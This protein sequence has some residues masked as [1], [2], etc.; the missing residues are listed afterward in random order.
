[1]PISGT[2]IISVCILQIIGETFHA[3]FSFVKLAVINLL[4]TIATSFIGYVLP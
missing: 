3:V 1:M 2:Q 4:I